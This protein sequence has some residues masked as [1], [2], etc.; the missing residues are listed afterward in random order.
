MLSAR[1][2]VGWYNGLPQDSWLRPPL[3]EA[4]HVAVLGHGNVALDVARILLT[5][6]HMLKVISL[7]HCKAFLKNTIILSTLIYQ[8]GPIFFYSTI[9]YYEKFIINL[10]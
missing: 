4:E 1:Q 6:L 7:Q 3:Q 2:F 8:T 5:P 9:A 10:L